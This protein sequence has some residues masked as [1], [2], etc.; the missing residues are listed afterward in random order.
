MNRNQITND[1]NVNKTKKKKKKKTR[2]L[3]LLDTGDAPVPK[4]TPYPPS[5]PMT[6]N[7]FNQYWRLM[8]EMSKSKL[9]QF[10]QKL[11]FVCRKTHA[12]LHY[13]FIAV[14]SFKMNA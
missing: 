5:S 10:C 11:Y 6:L 8:S 3:C 2:K 4:A 13:A 1:H 7:T 9:Q 14:Q 12:H